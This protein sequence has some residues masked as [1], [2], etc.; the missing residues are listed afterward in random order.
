MI[1]VFKQVTKITQALRLKIRSCT[2]G[3]QSCVHV[4]IP[5]RKSGPSSHDH[6]KHNIR[7]AEP[8]H[9]ASDVEKLADY[10]NAPKGL[11]TT[12]NQGGEVT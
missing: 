12:G 11:S 7:E 3:A 9:L 6:L 8:G 1:K 5:R 4:E 2:Q 10:C